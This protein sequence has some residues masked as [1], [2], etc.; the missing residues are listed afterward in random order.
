MYDFISHNSTNDLKQRVELSE[1]SLHSGL[2]SSKDLDYIKN[3]VGDRIDPWDT[4]G[5]IFEDVV[6][7]THTHWS[8]SLRKDVS[9]CSGRLRAQ[10]LSKCCT[11][12]HDIHS[13]ML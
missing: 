4:H 9:H 10:H 1:S 8:L 11:I 6:F 2:M 12:F 3:K 5:L 13:Q 7:A